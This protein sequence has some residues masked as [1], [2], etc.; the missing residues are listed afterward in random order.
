VVSR[1]ALP[2]GHL[3]PVPETAAPA[4]IAASERAAGYITSGM[5]P[6]QAKQMKRY[7]EDASVTY[8]FADAP[9][10]S[11]FKAHMGIDD[12]GAT[13]FIDRANQVFHPG[14]G[15]TGNSHDDD[16]DPRPDPIDWASNGEPMLSIGFRVNPNATQRANG[17][18]KHRVSASAEDVHLV[19]SERFVE[20]PAGHAT[21]EVAN[22]WVDARTRG[23][24]LVD[25][26]TLPLSQI[27]VG[28]NDLEVYATRDGDAVQV[29]VRAPAHPAV[30]SASDASGKVSEQLRSTLRSLS[31]SLPDGNSGGGRCG[32]V[33]FALRP[34]LDEGQIATMQS[35]AFLP[36]L[37]GDV[38]PAT[39]DTSEEL[40]A[41][42]IFQALRQ[43]PF[44]LSI[45][46]SASS[47]DKTPWVTIAV[48]WV[49]RERKA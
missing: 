47:A 12:S 48:G 29:V 14:D 17:G 9:S 27:Y 16:A 15:G 39:P 23:V 33:R 30:D 24:R 45:S 46:A 7:Q 1:A 44:Q 42:E 10:A 41:S 2:A 49:G 8:L 31:V 40:R 32:H 34:S 18:R 3:A 28:P 19:H 11:H 36:P 37:E 13:C 6:E 21:L 43:R 5:P 20:G 4:H 22:A 38:A 26:S 35:I 25:R